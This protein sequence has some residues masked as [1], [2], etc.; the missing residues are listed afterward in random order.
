L[1]EAVF[2]EEADTEQKRAIRTNKYKYIQASSEEDAL[3]LECDRIHGGVEELYDLAKDPAETNNII[4][5]YPDVAKKLSQ[6][7]FQWTELL[8]SKKGEKAAP[9]I[10]ETS[11]LYSEEERLIADK[12][13]ELGY[14]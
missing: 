10:K 4:D 7:L 2:I 11:A 12:L 9:K 5:E 14:F 1:R 3:C 8:K 6:G 13:K